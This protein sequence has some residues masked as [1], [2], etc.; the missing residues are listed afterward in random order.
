MGRSRSS[1]RSSDSS[2]VSS[3]DSNYKRK[4]SRTWKSSRSRVNRDKTST[5][6]IVGGSS[7]RSYTPPVSKK[8]SKIGRLE[9]LVEKLI[10]HQVEQKPE[11]FRAYTKPE[12]I[13]E[14]APGNPNLSAAK[15]IEKIE[16]LGVLNHWSD[17]TMIFH[18]QNRLKGLAR[19]WFDN[20]PSYQL[21]WDDWKE[22]L[23]RSFP[24]HQDFGTLLHKLVD[25]TKNPNESWEQYYFD[26]MEL[27]NACDITGKRAISCIIDGIQDSTTQAGAR[28]GRY[29]TPDAL[30]AEY[31]S[32]LK[33]ERTERTTILH[34]RPYPVMQRYGGGGPSQ[35]KKSK[36]H[37]HTNVQRC[38]NCKERGHFSNKCTKPKIECTSCKRLG[39]LAKDCRRS[40][41]VKNQIVQDTYS[42]CNGNYYFDC[43]VNG[44][45]LQAYVD[46]GC[47]AVLLKEDEAK[48]LN[49]IYDDSDLMITGY[50][51]SS[52]RVLGKAKVN[53]KVDQ[54]EAEVEILIVPNN[55][56]DIPL[57]VGQTF[58][59]KTNAM[60]ISTENTVRI[61]KAD[62]D[63]TEVLNIV[64]RKI[65]LWAI[66]STVI[67][68]KT[69]ALIAVTSRGNYSGEV[70]VRGGWRSYPG[71]EHFVDECVT[72]A[73]N[74]YITV[75]NLSHN[76]IELRSCQR[77]PSNSTRRI[78][79][80]QNGLHNTRWPL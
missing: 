7:Q 49:I 46:T 70:Y 65:P 71:K 37:T 36:L 10:K 27:L 31:L 55:A 74:G 79:H 67:P 24:E 2:S 69:T 23:L 72:N 60:L 42:D 59:N 50:G 12:S 38:Y 45:P 62:N 18:M 80:S 63:L 16:Q 53:L 21:T 78:V 76:E 25:R 52:I 11:S 39:H 3:E 5:V 64:P 20:L 51:G 33:P 26:K 56:Q 44:K 75:S 13:P 17:E 22:T 34:K 47:A 30:Y 73:E 9:N 1:S 6:E 28:A 68:P 48:S 8:K 32:A 61:L 43:W 77:V 57:M 4:K 58:L 40:T 14:F 15:W 29:E 66:R 19:R 54:V 35:D 41:H